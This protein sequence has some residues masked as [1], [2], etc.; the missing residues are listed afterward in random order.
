MNQR[1]DYRRRDQPLRL[2]SYA[3]HDHLVP[4]DLDA[5]ITGLPVRLIHET[6]RE[7]PPIRYQPGPLTRIGEG[8]LGVAIVATIVAA[9]THS[10][11]WLD[12]IRLLAFWM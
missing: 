11:E 9:F 7:M 3:G 1:R 10:S 2:V 4:V 6:Q 12:W 5:H 8:A